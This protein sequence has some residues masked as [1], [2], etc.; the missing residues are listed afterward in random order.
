[1]RRLRFALRPGW[2]VLHVVSLALVVTMILLGRWQLDVSDSKHFSLQNFGYAL[3]W[4][5]FSIFVIVFWAR[6]LRDAA[7]KRDQEAARAQRPAGEPE[8]RPAPAEEPVAYRRY[9]MPSQQQ[10]TAPAD[11]AHAAYNDYLARL[12]AQDA[13]NKQ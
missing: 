2:M 3:Q 6:I 13:G 5:A 8:P 11:A 10:Q 7:R 1:M 12:A 4:W 9:V